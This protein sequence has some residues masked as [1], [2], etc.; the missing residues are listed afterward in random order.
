MLCPVRPPFTQDFA[1]P[2]DAQTAPAI[3]GRLTGPGAF[4]DLLAG[5]EKVQANAIVAMAMPQ[6]EAEIHVLD[7]TVTDA[8]Y[9]DRS[10][11]GALSA[12][13]TE[14]T[15][16]LRLLPLKE[17]PRN[18]IG[19]LMPAL[20]ERLRAHDNAATQPLRGVLATDAAT[21]MPIPA[22]D[23]TN[24]QLLQ[25]AK[26][27]ERSR[28]ETVLEHEPARPGPDD[29]PDFPA[30]MIASLVP[31]AMRG[32]TL[33]GPAEPEAWTP[34][35]VGSMLGKCYLAT[36]IGRGATAIVFRALHIS[37]KIDV[38]VK[39][40]LPAAD[41][42]RVL[43]LDE[44]QLLARLN[45]PSIMRILDC[46]ED[47]PYPHLV[48]EYIDGMSLSELIQQSG[49]LP[50]AQAVRI[51]IS[52][53]EGLGHAATL[54]IVHCDVK[55]GN[56]LISRNFREVK[57]SDLGLAR[58]IGEHHPSSDQDASRVVVGTPAYIAP[59]QVLNGL[60]GVTPRSDIYSLGATLYHAVTGR[61]PFQDPD[62]IKTMLAHVQQPLTP[63]RV[64]LPGL[65]AK[66]DALIV[67]MLDKTPDYRPSDYDDLLFKLRAISERLSTQS[68]EDGG[69]ATNVNGQIYQT[70]TTAWGVVRRALDRV[71]K[72]G[73]KP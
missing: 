38:A 16:P 4:V 58:S 1:M 56:I 23:T 21:G 3:S 69:P 18:N 26:V 46:T 71:L 8:A 14:A 39:V 54:G 34:P 19:L 61:P 25:S 24:E 9:G 37:L 50:A 33:D 40:F 10:G 5:L 44:A 60:A 55:P 11:L 51:A 31:D 27:V 36:E 47:G 57:V 73:E 59:E 64:L 72:P 22:A 30:D 52:A 29:F 63:P 70:L 45:H 13:A 32:G 42:S 62:P 67:S 49:R 35:V 43:H 48:V 6:G 20:L 66:L 41:G 15:G 28:K 53:A 2:K 7:G 68:V 12:I 65:D 17:K